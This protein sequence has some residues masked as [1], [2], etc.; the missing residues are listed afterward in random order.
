MNID[1]GTRAAIIMDMGGTNISATSITT[2]ITTSITTSITTN[3]TKYIETNIGATRIDIDSRV[4]STNS[5]RTS[6]I[7]ID[8]D[9]RVAINI[10]SRGAPSIDIDI[11]IDIDRRVAINIDSRGAPSIDID[12]RPR[13]ISTEAAPS[14]R[15]YDFDT[16]L[17]GA[18]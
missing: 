14:T 9:R 5:R 11:D 7:D 10:D 12:N 15:S 17:G 13:V 2:N 8:I 3:I 1:S 18:T 16:R 4:I 6:S